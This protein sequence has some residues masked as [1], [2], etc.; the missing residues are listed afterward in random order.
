[1]A[2]LSLTYFF[3]VIG[4]VFGLHHLYLGRYNQ[5]VL[6]ASTFAF[7]GLGLIYD[8]FLL[9]Q[10]VKQTNGDAIWLSLLRR[11]MKSRPPFSFPLALVCYVVSYA[12]SH[13]ALVSINFLEPIENRIGAK[14]SDL[15][16]YWCVLTSLA[17]SIGIFCGMV[18]INN[19]TGQYTVSRSYLF[20]SV[21]V[22][23][24]LDVLLSQMTSICMLVVFRALFPTM[25][26]IRSCEWLPTCADPRPLPHMT[27]GKFSRI[28]TRFVLNV[29]VILAIFCAS[30]FCYCD[31]FIHH[32]GL[33]EYSDSNYGISLNTIN[34]FVTRWTWTSVPSFWSQD[35]EDLLVSEDDNH[36]H[37]ID[38]HREDI[39]VVSKVN[40][41]PSS[42]SSSP[43]S[44][45]SPQLLQS[46]NDFID[47]INP[48]TPYQSILTYP[49]FSAQLT[50]LYF[51]TILPLY[52][53]Q[54]QQLPNNQSNNQIV[55]IPA[56]HILNEI[57]SQSLHFPQHYRVRDI[58]RNIYFSSLLSSIHHDMPYYRE[59]I[60]SSIANPA[61]HQ[62]FPARVLQTMT[63]PSS[64]LATGA[65]YVNRLLFGVRCVYYFIVNAI[66][67]VQ[68]HGVHK[69]V[70]S[71]DLSGYQW[72]RNYLA[73]ITDPQAITAATTAISARV[74]P[75][76]A[77]SVDVSSFNVMPS[78]N[79]E[80]GLHINQLQ[81]I[82]FVH[83]ST[84][85]HSVH[86]VVKNL[87]FAQQKH[88]YDL[89]AIYTRLEP[90]L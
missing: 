3:L 69:F 52:T 47:I 82:I 60:L 73:L 41:L 83:M 17:Q 11:R 36:I 5:A 18:F 40:D 31:V 43:S 38:H 44:V 16:L 37:G 57:F 50:T 33:V 79:I 49:A 15:P 26:Y 22:G 1:M 85:L 88:I 80:S 68:Q 28:Y 10:Y 45:S 53:A 27:I 63:S 59:N 35:S 78:Y 25:F 51:N 84:L 72:A 87:S 14:F 30:V 8:F 67:C 62:S 12:M 90:H 86:G 71:L 20:V 65:N 58:C 74:S 19:I 34:P 75:A 4:G 13:L 7:F 61:Q 46:N 23:T 32:N 77:H 66:E 24:I 76:A 55:P 81:R 48:I 9:P 56:D 6:Y 89:L 54:Q 39:N 29:F 42:A 64:L 21:L 70:S 2:R